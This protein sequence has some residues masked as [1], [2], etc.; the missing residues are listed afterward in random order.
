MKQL[1]VLVV[2]DDQ[3]FA[4]S[5]A[6]VLEGRGHKVELAYD[7]KQ[8]IEKFQNQNFDV[9]F[10]DV[11]L[12]GMDGVESFLEVRKFKPYAKVIMMT[13]YSVEQLLE[14]AVENGAWGVLHKPLDI[15][16]LLEMLE[17][18]RPAGILIADDD[19]DFLESLREVLVSKGWRV[20]VAKDGKEAVARM[21]SDGIDILIL[22]LR[23][24]ILNGLET[25]LELEQLG[26]TVPTIVVTAYADEEA[27]SI[28]RLL[29]MHVK[30]IMRK[31]FNPED[32]I[33]TLE[34]MAGSAG[35]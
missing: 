35:G 8:A 30:G 6:M 16:E 21:R 7:G 20:L 3:D 34:G 15:E 1:D 12:P 28:N 4:E 27:E 33:E 9:A 13:G 17:Q 22:D 14:R 23:M 5:L 29:S 10:M 19:E 2:E 32:L 11:I 26:L 18:V 24:P 25:Y 31:P